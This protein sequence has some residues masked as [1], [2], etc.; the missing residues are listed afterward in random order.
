[1]T[2]L[3]DYFEKNVSGYEIFDSHTVGHA[4]RSV[5]PDTQPNVQKDITQNL[6]YKPFIG[7]G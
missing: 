2:P 3:I 7:C 1:M 6:T 4:L 5:H